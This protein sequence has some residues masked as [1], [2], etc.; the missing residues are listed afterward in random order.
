M[1][2]KEKE[3][4]VRFGQKAHTRQTL[5]KKEMLQRPLSSL[6]GSTTKL[7]NALNQGPTDSEV[8]LDS[9]VGEYDSFPLKE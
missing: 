3:D 2:E 4:A 8:P 7:L 5:S 1:C 9:D 6:E